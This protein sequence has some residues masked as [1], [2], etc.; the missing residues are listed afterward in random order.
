M[1][2]LS[3]KK[4]RVESQRERIPSETFEAGILKN[5]IR[6]TWHGDTKTRGEDKQLLWQLDLHANN[7]KSI[8]DSLDYEIS[9]M[10][11]V[12]SN[13]ASMDKGDVKA[14]L[15]HLETIALGYSHMIGYDLTNLLM[16]GL[17]R[18]AKNLQSVVYYTNVLFD[19]LE[20]RQKRYEKRIDTE[21]GS[22]ERLYNEI[23][24]HNASFISRLFRKGEIRNLNHK[25]SGKNA[26]VTKLKGRHVRYSSLLSKLKSQLKDR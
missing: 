2:T 19:N 23:A 25:L 16:I 12:A 15:A 5:V 22:M 1:A 7:M 4:D 3:T 26:R 13:T 21:N 17:A 20:N 24:M 14:Y 8:L 18:K 10:P 9:A 11:L 6:E